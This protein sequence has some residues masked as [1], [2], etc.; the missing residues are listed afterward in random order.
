MWAAV[1]SRKP[2]IILTENGICDHH[3]KQLAA[4][5]ELAELVRSYTD[6]P[7]RTGTEADLRR[8]QNNF[9]SPP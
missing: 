7:I 1:V 5:S 2:A 6:A 9:I 8:L 4:W 3:G